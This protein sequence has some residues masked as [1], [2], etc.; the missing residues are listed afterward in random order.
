[1]VTGKK[2]RGPDRM[3]VWP[4]S[5]GTVMKRKKKAAAGRPR[6]I[7]GEH[8][9]LRSRDDILRVATAEFARSGLSGARVDAIAERTR[10]SKRMIYYHFGSKEAL[11]L[12]VLEKAYADIR[13]FES[14]H[15][16]SALPPEAA[17]RYLIELTFD[18]DESHPDFIRLVSIE[19]I[20]RAKHIK[21]SA[22]LRSLNNSVIDVLRDILDRGR[23]QGVFRGAVDAIDVHMLISAFCFFRISNQYTFGVAF[24]RDLAAPETRARHKALIVEAVLRFLKSEPA[25]AATE[26]ASAAH[27]MEHG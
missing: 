18:Y 15:A 10:T 27:N 23:R 6:R 25:A 26:R 12:A 17:M 11:Y 20:H 2:V 21:S 13:S 16:L 1:M 24:G 22:A 3:R 7:G 4:A 8:T 14:A 19:N 5:A 9:A